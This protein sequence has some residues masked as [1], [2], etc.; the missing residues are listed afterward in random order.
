MATLGLSQEA[1]AVINNAIQISRERQDEDLDG[2]HL[3]AALFSSPFGQGW[4]DH[5]GK[6]QSQYVCKELENLFN[7]RD[8]CIAEFPEPTETYLRIMQVA[9]YKAKQAGQNLLTCDYLLYAIFE[10]DKQL[11]ERLFKKIPAYNFS[12]EKEFTHSL[13]RVGRDLTKLARENE[14]NPVFGRDGEIQQLI[15]V[16]LRRGKNSAIL[17][18]PAGV[19]KTAIV[20][21]LAIKISKGEVPER[22]KDTH[23]IEL[24]LAS[25]LAGTAYRGEF[26]EEA[27]ITYQ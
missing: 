11:Q 13:D 6:E 2:I 26:E 25:L 14:L 10:Q 18:G 8:R 4:L 21:G 19:G 9:E 27:G 23:L 15:E 17:I 22:L 12:T 3:L 5:I 16:L 7:E 1:Q 20:E 24:N